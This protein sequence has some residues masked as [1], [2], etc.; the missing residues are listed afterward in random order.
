MKK[1]L[2]IFA[3]LTALFV[4]SCQK[5]V[6][7]QVE[8][9]S[10]GKVTVLKASVT[11]AETKVSAD[12]VGKFAWQAGDAITAFDN[13]NNNLK[14]TT[15]NGGS[16][17][18]FTFSG[19]ATLGTY[20][21]YPYDANHEVTGDHVRVSLPNEYTYKA[22]ETNMPML[23][24]IENNQASFKAVGGVLKL[25]I[26][27]VPEGATKLT[28]T[29]TNKQISGL[30]DID[31]AS[32][33]EPVIE[34][35]NT[36]TADDK[37]VAINFTRQANM[38]FYIP[39]PTG[40]IDG[41]TLAFDDA[42]STTK[43]VTAS[44]IVGRNKIINAPALN[45]TAVS[46]AVLT[47]AEIL[48]AVTGSYASNNIASSS[49]TWS[50]TYGMKQASKLQIKKESDGGK[51]T[52][53]SF[54][55]NITKIVLEGTG[56]GGGS[57]FNGTVYFKNS[58]T[59]EIIASKSVSGISLGDNITI[60]VPS[61]NTTGYITADGVIRIASV[62][63][64]F[65]NAGTFPSLAATDDDLEIAVGSLTAT[66]TV[67]LSNPV[68]ALGISC[69]VN[70]EAK[71][72]L[73]ASISGSTLTVTAA[74]ANS[75]PAD[76]NGTVTLKA[77]GVANVV[78]S[79]TQPT[80]MVANPSVTATAGDSKFTATWAGVPHAT[81]YVAYLH[82]ALTNTPA[83][84]G[85]NI[86]ASISESAGTYS[87]TDYAVTNDT[88]Y[89]LYVKV[90][91]VESNYEAVSEYA[92]VDFT[93]AEAKGTAENPYLAN[94]LYT[95]I[96]TGIVSD[97]TSVYVKG[98]VSYASNPSSNSQ[99][100]FISDNGTG[101]NSGT[102]QIYKGK[103]I[104][105]ANMTTDN[106]VNVGD[107]V[108]VCGNT[109]YYN[110]SKPEINSGNV[111]VTHY[112]F[113]ID[114][115]EVEWAWNETSAEDFTV[116]IN[117]SGD[118]KTFT[119]SESGMDW[120]TVTV[121]GNV[122]TI[123]PNDSNSSL[124]ADRAGTVTVHHASDLFDDIVISCT[125]TKAPAH[126]ISIK[127]NPAR[128]DLSGIKDTPTEITV[129]SNYAW[130][131]ANTGS[132]Y[133]ISPTSGSAGETVVTITPSADG[134]ATE[135]KLGDVTFTDAVDGVTAV[136]KDIYQAAKASSYT[137]VFKKNSGDGTSV[138]TSTACSAIVSDGASF[139]SGNVVTATNVYYNGSDGLKLG[140]SGGAGVIK[141]NLSSTI[142]P[143]SIVVHAKRYNTSKTVNLSVNESDAQSLS[144]SSSF[145]EYTF[146]ISSEISFIQ[147]NSTQYCWIESIT[148]NY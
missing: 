55:S 11:E 81:S 140:K 15:T 133:T 123:T 141:M 54:T 37:S 56:N 104:D 131:S 38:V 124:V 50:Y 59:N 68:D 60:D 27:N 122:I 134:G 23:G 96:A 93:P 107:W 34:T 111:L 91:E 36:S 129:V 121:V 6:D 77:T 10:K 9:I 92:V 103:G 18:E 99:N 127:T 58:N 48:V 49:G 44:F 138:S 102:L 83:S 28:F 8:P 63:V 105:N 116:S 87:I 13:T 70:D 90:N 106:R 45:C 32:I 80:K 125:Q 148:V 144:T 112:Y 119:H 135:T 128:I 98:Y 61:G 3:A 95:A 35:A 14:F 1:F 71:S 41:F 20:A 86:T 69:V 51:L 33:A 65:V 24:K 73:S 118:Y 62:T 2:P 72:W 139:L 85:T 130:T 120:A 29:A 42:N 64:K 78:V 126:E 143:T 19:D 4:S 31:N 142:T 16:N 115:D 5:E 89:Y 145:A 17:T 12:A 21:I 52:L 53:P 108:V 110:S 84:G 30:F 40:E 101:G 147:L 75:T 146:D 57:A 79:V 76:R 109:L 82:T 46:D 7:K 43:N 67:T 97:N 117:A 66:T 136:T 26:Y 74:E 137:I 88:H 94:E 39:L 22:D 113:G 132:G 25:I 47:N 114:Y 100:Y